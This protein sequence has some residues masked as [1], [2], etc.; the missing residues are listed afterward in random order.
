MRNVALYQGAVGGHVEG[1][2]ETGA[3]AFQ[4]GDQHP[5]RLVPSR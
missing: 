5:N 4:R 2:I 3:R 1:A